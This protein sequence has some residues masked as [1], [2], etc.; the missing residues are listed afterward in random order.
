MPE[1]Q[2]NGSSEEE[3]CCLEPFLQ[4]FEVVAWEGVKDDV[5]AKIQVSRKH[6]CH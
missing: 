5:K 2:K 4:G 1:K 6:W 3:R